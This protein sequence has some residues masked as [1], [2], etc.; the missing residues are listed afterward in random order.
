MNVY[1]YVINVLKCENPSVYKVT[2]N[3][4]M[5]V[6][7]MMMTSLQR[8]N[9]AS[10]LTCGTRVKGF[11]C[12]FILGMIF[13]FLVSVSMVTTCLSFP[14][15]TTCRSVSTVTACL[16]VSRVSSCCGSQ[17][18]VLVCSLPSTVGETS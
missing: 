15:V 8:A 2:T 5:T 6:M 10:T 12:C 9:E 4:L 7:M 17:V 14:I 11:V 16:F 3:M 13:S 1:V 18:L